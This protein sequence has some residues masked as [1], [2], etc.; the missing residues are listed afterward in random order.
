MLPDQTYQLLKR[1]YEKGYRPTAEETAALRARG[2]GLS[3][4]TPV[5][6]DEAGARLA[7]AF[8]NAKRQDVAGAFLY[9]ITSGR[10]E[11]RTGLAAYAYAMHFPKHKFTPGQRRPDICSVCGMRPV[12]EFDFAKMYYRKFDWG[13][14]LRTNPLE[15]AYDLEFFNALPPVAPTADDIK[16]FRAIIKI[17]LAAAPDDTG[18]KIQEKT[19]K[20]LKGN[21]YTRE[22]FFETL[23]ICGILETKDFKGYNHQF[24]TVWEAQGGKSRPHKFVEC[25]PPLSFWR[26]AD[27]F[28]DLSLRYF[29]GPWLGR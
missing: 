12:E 25:D 14:G 18:R 11:Y 6:H 3:V 9:S 19:K 28:N 1:Y 27:G 17:I 15:P 4:K 21:K 29:F 23:G 7:K 8:A 2:F 10:M 22:Y 24:M 16:T 20:L 13:N 5:T 26:G